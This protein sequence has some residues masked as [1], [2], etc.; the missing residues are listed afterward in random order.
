VVIDSAAGR[1]YWANQ[2][3][4]TISYANLDGSGGGG[5]LNI[6]GTT[7]SKPHGLAI[8]PS[9]GK[10]YWA[11]DNDTISYANLDGSGG[12]QLDISGATPSAPYGAAI[13]TATGRIYW[14]NRINNT[15]SYANLDDSGGG[16]ELG[17]SGG[18]V[19]DPHGVVIDAAGGRIYWANADSKISFANLDGSGGGGLLNLTGANEIGGVGMAI[20]PTTGRLYWGNLGI[21]AIPISYANLDGSGGGPLNTSGATGNKARFPALLRAPSATGA[22]QIAGGATRGSVL[23]C[24]RGTWAPDVLGSFFYRAPRSFAFQWLWKNSAIRGASGSSYAPRAAGSYRCQVTATNQAGSTAQTSAPLKVD[25]SPKCTRLRN[26]RRRQKLGLA[27]ATD[28]RR[29]H[30][31]ANIEHTEKRLRRLGCK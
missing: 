27:A 20:D 22:P 2:E 3:N 30:I 6:A 16:D 31:Q 15:I 17:L 8:D 29:P 1:I 21:D 28:K 7:P 12:G 4:A 13:D 11:N 18:T 9:A 19:F 14:A 24:S 25:K 23:S 26:K 5:E 10:I